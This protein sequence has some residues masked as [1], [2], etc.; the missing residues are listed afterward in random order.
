MNG[1]KVIP[2]SDCP[3]KP[4]E[5]G[6]CPVPSQKGLILQPC[7]HCQ[8]PKLFATNLI[9]QMLP[10]F[11]FFF[12]AF[13]FAFAPFNYTQLGF[14]PFS[15]SASHCHVTGLCRCS[16]L[17]LFFFFVFFIAPWSFMYPFS[18]LS[19]ITLMRR[20][21]KRMSDSRWFH[22]RAQTERL[23]L[24]LTVMWCDFLASNGADLS[25]LLCVCKV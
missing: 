6:L 7:S 23:L 17:A 21:Q 16:T 4:L 15:L 25:W 11:F 20:C 24:Y 22:L 8:L 1:S 10:S 14:M 2:I 19:P 5:P 18:E 9:W 12:F 13:A 3:R